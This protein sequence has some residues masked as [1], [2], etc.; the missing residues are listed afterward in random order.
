MQAG[1]HVRRKAF[2]AEI[3]GADKANGFAS[4]FQQA[5]DDGDF[6]DEELRLIQ[7]RGM[8]RITIFHFEDQR[9]TAGVIFPVSEHIN[10]Q[11]GRLLRRLE[12]KVLPDARERRGAA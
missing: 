4:L 2:G 10:L 9:P 7:G 12:I 6:G 3:D 8:F 1:F 11:R 5:A